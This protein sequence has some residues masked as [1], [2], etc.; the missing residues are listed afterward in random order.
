MCFN[1][2][3]QR[4]GLSVLV[5]IVMF[6]FVLTG[7]VTASGETIQGPERV[8]LAGSASE[9]AFF[10]I[11]KQQRHASVHAFEMRATPALPNDFQIKLASFT[12]PNWITLNRP[13]SL[14]EI[15]KNQCGDID[16]EVM[17]HLLVMTRKLNPGMIENA[18]LVPGVE[19][20]LPTCLPIIN[21]VHKVVNSQR[22]ISEVLRVETGD[23]SDRTV[24]DV[25]LLNRFVIC[26]AHMPLASFVFDS[27]DKSQTATFDLILPFKAPKNTVFI[28][29]QNLHDI[30][31]DDTSNNSNANFI[32]IDIKRVREKPPL[33][34]KMP[35]KLIELLS[36]ANT[37]KFCGLTPQGQQD[38][39]AAFEAD[40]IISALN[41]EMTIQGK[42][43][44]TKTIIGIVDTGIGGTRGSPVFAVKEEGQTLTQIERFFLAPN[45]REYISPKDD[46]CRSGC[47]NGLPSNG[48]DV[49]GMRV[50][51]QSIGDNDET[52]KFWP[53][54]LLSAR[55]DHA[56]HGTE[57]MSLVLGGPKF[58]EHLR[59]IYHEEARRNMQSR[60]PFRLKVI[61]FSQGSGGMVDNRNDF[62]DMLTYL[63]GKKVNIVNMS[64]GDKGPRLRTLGGTLEDYGDTLLFVAA[65]GNGNENLDDDDQSVYPAAFGG[66]GG[67]VRNNLISVGG[68]GWDG[69]KAQGSAFSPSKVDL[70]APACGVATHTFKAGASDVDDENDPLFFLTES[71][72]KIDNRAGTSVA[73]A[74]TSFTAGLVHQ[75][76]WN[77]VMPREVKT[78]LVTSG[79][80]THELYAF[81]SL[82]VRLNPV[83]AISVSQDIID[84]TDGVTG[85]RKLT[86]SVLPAN[87]IENLPMMLCKA[88]PDKVSSGSD[89]TFAVVANSIKKKIQKDNTKLKKVVF[90]KRPGTEK[91][92][93]FWF[94]Q[95]TDQALIGI[96]KCQN[97]LQNRDLKWQENG[98]SF[99]INSS[100]ISDITLMSSPSRIAVR[101][102]LARELQ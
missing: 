36:E 73:T 32:D 31:A 87:M 76:M 72:Y 14:A 63:K 84:W 80:I 50:N 46:D 67:P 68:L 102:Q 69:S 39:R 15:L 81:S 7:G 20:A 78:R 25:C 61:N 17:D 21:R 40:Q 38:W 91:E 51:D 86:P 64:M 79:D 6:C 19:L 47:F 60:A 101:D 49:Y 42:R 4:Q 59:S 12:E 77:D 71:R 85:K 56:R 11:E 74:L 88:T 24:K 35:F 62:E 8:S 43:F 93:E 53:E 41:R 26:D 48:N 95:R 57:M 58:I 65:A 96:E 70:F 90:S 66:N 18:D 52:I 45:E 37:D 100:M 9:A 89:Q 99:K 83:K 30:F 28:A 55:P 27:D 23:T 22:S 54:T 44:E 10:S 82:P 2:A 92:I 16:P 1:Q 13:A 97:N 34:K 94:E 3:E 29:D 33:P 75:L 5:A 98:E